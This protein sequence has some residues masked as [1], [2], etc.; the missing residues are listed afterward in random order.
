VRLAIPAVLLLVLAGGC[1]SGERSDGGPAS[2][3]PVGEV[4]ADGTYEVGVDLLPGVYT[5]PAG[6]GCG[7]IAASTADYDVEEM[8]EDPD[9]YLR[10]SVRVGDLQRI[11][12]KD[13]EFFQTSSC[14][15]WQREDG[16]GAVSPD[17]AT[18]AGGCAILVGKDDL[19][20]RAF[21]YRGPANTDEASELQQRLFAIVVSFNK[22]LTDPAGQLVDFLD[23]PAGYVENGEVIPKVAREMDRVR[24][25]CG[26]P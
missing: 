13:G 2:G 17:P 1:G 19:A 15:R 25:L 9:E 6:G 26:K 22:E 20:V 11:P 18:L 16:T 21:E 14:G 7:A 5:A 10:G 3:A 24:E 8:R 12:L 4:T 23:D